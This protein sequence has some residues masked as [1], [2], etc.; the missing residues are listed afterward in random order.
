MAIADDLAE[1]Y[2]TKGLETFEGDRV[3]TQTA[4]ALQAATLAERAGAQ[5]EMIVAALLHDIGRVINPR[6][7]E[8][9]DKGGDAKHEEV[10]RAYLSAW[11]GPAVTMPVNWHVAAKRYLVATDPAYADKVSGGSRCSLAGQGGAMADPDA[12][13]AFLAEPY[14]RD[15]VTLRRWDDAA[16]DPAAAPPPFDHFRRYIEACAAI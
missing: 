4:H 8:I 13:A 6:D 3:L 12:A 11:F 5:P 14:A 15:G 2:A 16:K 10:G 7:R 1:L 9:T